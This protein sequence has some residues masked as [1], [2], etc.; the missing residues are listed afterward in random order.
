M[1]N[2]AI[3]YHLN[4]Y[5]DIIK[6]LYISL[7]WEELSDDEAER[8]KKEM[9]SDHKNYETEIKDLTG[10][11]FMVTKTINEDNRIEELQSLKV[12]GQVQVSRQNHPLSVTH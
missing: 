2:C 7:D 12:C 8:E 6:Q 10:I 3:I 9:E 11:D 4:S 5:N 1:E